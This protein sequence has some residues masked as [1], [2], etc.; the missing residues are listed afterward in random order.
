MGYG[1]GGTKAGGIVGGR[2]DGWFRK[3]QIGLLASGDGDLAR[4]VAA[5]T[6]ASPPEV[7]PKYH[8]TLGRVEGREM[9]AQSQAPLEERHR[10]LTSSEGVGQQS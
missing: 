2:V 4:M 9:D 1:D 3:T 8:T 7:A 6:L 5:S 10:C